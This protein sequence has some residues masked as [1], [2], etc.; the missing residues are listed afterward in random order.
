MNFPWLVLGALGAAAISGATARLTRRYAAAAIA[1]SAAILLLHSSL[2][3]HYTSD[4]AYISY[5]YARNLSD[6]LGL[7]WNPGQHVEGYSN[8]LWVVMIAGLDKVGADIVLSGRWLGFALAVGAAGGAYYLATRVVDGAAGRI[9]GLVAALLLASSGTWALWASAGLEPPLFAVLILAAVA[10]HLHERDHPSFGG[11]GAVWALAVMARPDALVLVGVSA[12]FKLGDAIMRVPTGDGQLRPIA[13]ELAAF[14][15]WSAA[16]AAVFA[17]YFAWRYTTY[18]WLYPNTYYAKVGL[19]LTQYDRGLRYVAAFLEESGG[20]LLLVVPFA[21]AFTSERRAI[22]LYLFALLAAWMTYIV[23][24]GGDSLLRFRFFAP[25]MPLFYALVVASIAAIVEA[26][27]AGNA[28]KRW[29]AQAT[30]GL[31]AAAALIFTLHPSAADSN[32]I[33]GERHAVADRVEIGRWLHANLPDTTT[34]AAVPVGAFA[35][36]SRLTVIDMLGI[37]DEHIAHRD[38][39]LGEFPAGHEK[40]DSEYVLDQHPDII[41]LFDDLSTSP[42]T[43]TDYEGLKSSFIPAVIDM[44]KSQRL[45]R[46]YTRRAAMLRDGKWLN[47]YVRLGSAPVLTRTEAA[48]P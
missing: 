47:V 26:I 46:E 45:A 34:V 29:R 9:A 40:Y 37:S 12:A 28:L 23:Y 35:Y 18:G 21:I 20:W 24:I 36:E 4:D 22:A 8:F 48:P 1:G 41:I 13:R 38:V 15:L 10:L 19:G 33:V 30:V 6:G 31:V 44:L 42:R 39:D 16:F 5:R 43:S 27:D 11:S 14:L 2:Y 3:F 7:V 25:V 32:L 17:P